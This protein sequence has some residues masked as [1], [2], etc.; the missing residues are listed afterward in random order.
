MMDMVWFCERVLNGSIYYERMLTGATSK[1]TTELFFF[2][3]L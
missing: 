1:G 2:L 3:L